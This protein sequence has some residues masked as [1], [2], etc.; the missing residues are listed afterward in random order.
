MAPWTVA[1]QAPLAIDIEFPR[2]NYWSELPFPT[3]ADPFNQ[4]SNQHLLHFLHWQA[5]SLP[6]CHL[7]SP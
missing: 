5:D 1:H 2:Q 3:L 6:V 4:G 7:E